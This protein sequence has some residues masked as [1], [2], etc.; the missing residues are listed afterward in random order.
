MKKAKRAASLILSVLMLAVLIAGCGT[1][2]GGPTSAPPRTAASP[3]PSEAAPPSESAEASVSEVPSEDTKDTIGY[4]TDKFDHFSRDPLKIAYIC[5]DISWAWNKAISDTL[6]NLA[7]VLNYDYI[8]YSANA[9]RITIFC[10]F[11]YLPTRACRASSP[12][13]TT[14][15]PPRF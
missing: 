7:D 2:G 3:S 9:T 13:S 11:R 10:S 1:N 12:V 15:L 8:A 5:N 6:E 4:L 14:P